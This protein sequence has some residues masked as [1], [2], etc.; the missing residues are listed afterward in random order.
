MEPCDDF[1]ALNEET[2]AEMRDLDARERAGMYDDDDPDEE[3]YE[4]VTP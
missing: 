1:E 3:R 2:D 4:E